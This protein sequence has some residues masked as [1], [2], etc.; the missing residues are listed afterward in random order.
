[1]I[2]KEI[3]LQELNSNMEKNKRER[4]VGNTRKEKEGEEKI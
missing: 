3:S 2:Q 1:M 4:R